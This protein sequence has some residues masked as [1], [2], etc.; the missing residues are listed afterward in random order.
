MNEPGPGPAAVN[1]S[2]STSN[3][4]MVFID[5]L[6][7]FAAVS[8]VFHHLTYNSYYSTTLQNLLPSIFALYCDYGR[9]GVDV[10]FVIS[11]FVISYSLRDNPADA[12]SLGNFILRRQLRLDPPY[13]FMLVLVLVAAW[14]FIAAPDFCYPR[15][16]EMG[17]KGILANF[18]YLQRITHGPELLLVAWTLCLEIQFYLLNIAVLVL[19]KAIGRGRRSSLIE[20]LILMITG[21]ASVAAVRN[22]ALPA[23]TVFTWFPLGWLYFAG[24]A[25]A[26]LSV[27]ER[28]PNIDGVFRSYLM[29]YAAILSV[30]GIHWKPYTAVGFVTIALIWGVG[31]AG[32][33]WTWLGQEA[34]Q[35]FGRISYSLYLIHFPITVTILD[36][37]FHH[38]GAD[39]TQ[40]SLVWFVTALIASIVAGHLL[41]VG[42]E[43]PSMRLAASFKRKRPE[44][45]PAPSP[46]PIAGAVPA[47][48]S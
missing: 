42:V 45:A 30:D 20:A 4:R 8:V 1:S 22:E 36:Y 34:F 10:F 25:L 3:S 23:G 9:Y 18:V 39:R 28:N 40:M 27:R 6:R 35:Y 5:A 32:K 26:D 48:L 14:W 16:W 44:P 37:G 29:L 24:G 7:G 33:L 43:R 19:A 41:Y 21:L 47:A 31:K 2:A 17:V 38:S 15:P 46:A 12:R 11:G 13:W